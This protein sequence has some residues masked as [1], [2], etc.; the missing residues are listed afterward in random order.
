MAEQCGEM[1]GG[2]TSCDVDAT[3]APIV[4][5]DVEETNPC[6]RPCV[7]L[8]E[9]IHVK[10]HEDLGACEAS[11]DDAAAREETGWDLES[12]YESL[13]TFFPDSAEAES[14]AYA[15]SILCLEERLAFDPTCQIPEFNAYGQHQ[16][17]AEK[18]Y[19]QANIDQA[20][21]D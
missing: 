5:K 19:L 21:S 16:L 9:S 4:V 2:D 18:C 8:H 17:E 13:N 1:I 11:A 12:F 20:E 15:A 7:D 3:G 6:V 10:Q 14:E